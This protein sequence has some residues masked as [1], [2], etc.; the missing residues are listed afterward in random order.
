MDNDASKVIRRTLMCRDHE[1]VRF[2]YDLALQR[3]V[4]RP[5]IIDE[6]FIPLGCLE[7]NGAFSSSR[8]QRW[9]SNRAVPATRPGLVPVLQR[10]GMSSPEELLAAGLGLSLSDQYWLM[11]D[12]AA[13]QWADVNFFDKPFSPALGEALAPHDPDSGSKALA[14][15]DDEGI[16]T[17]SSPDSALNGNLPKR[18]EIENGVRVLV[19]SGKAANLF[20]EPFNEYIATRLCSRI[21]DASDYVPYELVHNGYPVYVSSCP[22][23]VDERTEFVPAADI[24]L[25]MQ[26]R[27]DQSRFEAL[28]ERC[29]AN[30]IAD[31]RT[32][33]EHMLAVDH[34]MANID[35]HWGNFGIL[36]DS[37][38][39][40]WLRMVPIF[41]TGE[42]LWCDRALANDFSP[43][44]MPHPMPFLRDIGDQ[45]ERYARDLS[46]LDVNAVGGFADEAVEILAACRVCADMPGRLDGIHAAIERNIEDVRRAQN[47]R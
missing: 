25:S 47:S 15:L 8:L 5:S 3:V 24:I 7:P 28:A 17:A 14:R 9:L 34:I 20:Q 21:L 12:D 30:G 46:W 45:L 38:T 33:L 10:L 32:S 29:E 23:M 11:P 40:T 31:A 22:C 41:D 42:A 13:L 35:R 43:Y 19:K 1:A 27:N 4:G 16:V 2:S 39:R 26:V 37:E 18:W 36:M 6:S 44:H